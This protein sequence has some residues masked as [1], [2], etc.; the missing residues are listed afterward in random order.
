MSTY[1]NREMLKAAL[2]K[3]ADREAASDSDSDKEEED[4][5]APPTGDT[6]LPL[7]F[8]IEVKN[9]MD[10]ILRNYVWRVSL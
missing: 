10:T 1:L 6:E 9:W 7:G 3:E 2:G 5:E 8:G 4:Q